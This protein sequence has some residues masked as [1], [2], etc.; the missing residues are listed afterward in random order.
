MG[1]HQKDNCNFKSAEF[2]LADLEEAKFQCEKNLR[3]ISMRE[4]LEN[5]NQIS[6]YLNKQVHFTCKNNCF[7]DKPYSE[8]CKITVI[9]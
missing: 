3:D 5:L 9:F 6:L 1:L 8:I 7:L 2:F 4:I